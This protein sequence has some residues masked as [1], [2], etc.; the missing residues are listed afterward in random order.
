MSKDIFDELE[1][2][3]DD[4]FKPEKQKSNMFNETYDKLLREKWKAE[5]RARDQQKFRPVDIYDSYVVK[6]IINCVGCQTNIEF[7]TI[8]DESKSRFSSTPIF[9][10]M[11]YV[12]SDV[13]CP[14]CGCRFRCRGKVVK[15]KAEV[16]QECR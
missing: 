14:V 13:W 8:I 3:I 2:S 10:Q 7:H 16:N 12:V 6:D 4:A 15:I 9:A 11:D 1:K 5:A